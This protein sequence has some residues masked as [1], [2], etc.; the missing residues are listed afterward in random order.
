MPGCSRKVQ[1]YTGDPV[2]KRNT[3]VWSAGRDFWQ[4][5]RQEHAPCSHTPCPLS[6]CTTTY[7]ALAPLQSHYL[8]RH[9]T[10][11][12]PT[13]EV[14]WAVW[15][16]RIWGFGE[17]DRHVPLAQIINPHLVEQ[18]LGAEFVSELH[19]V[20]LRARPEVTNPIDGSAQ[21]R[22]GGELLFRHFAGL[23]RCVTDWGWPIWEP[24]AH[25]WLMNR[26]DA[27]YACSLAATSSRR[28]EPVL[29]HARRNVTNGW[30]PGYAC[31]TVWP[32]YNIDHFRGVIMMAQ[33]APGAYARLHALTSGRPP[34]AAWARPNV[35][36]VAVNYRQGAGATAPRP[37]KAVPRI[38][39][40]LKVQAQREEAQAAMVYLPPQTQAVTEP[41]RVTSL[42]KAGSCSTLSTDQIMRDSRWD[43]IEDPF[44][45][46]VLADPSQPPKV[47]FS[48]T[49]PPGSKQL[50]KEIATRREHYDHAVREFKK[51]PTDIHCRGS[52]GA[53][54]RLWQ[55]ALQVQQHRGYVN[56]HKHRGSRKSVTSTHPQVTGSSAPV[57]PQ[58]L[59]VSTRDPPMPG[60]PAN[61][62]VVQAL[63]TPPRQVHFKDRD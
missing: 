18:D 61:K 17:I 37:S 12:S 45:W 5:W 22:L 13:E 43:L 46:D 10:T 30:I 23:D 58:D 28:D 2:G 16:I 44:V 49:L 4:H 48:D 8:G 26:E 36:N 55:H 7:G 25:V 60:T 34:R 29:D 31:T 39:S 54:H 20:F 27:I 47:T 51:N 33:W 35:H 15:Q 50:T 59:R 32:Q 53:Y 62:R 6:D 19:P 1:V 9:D 40:I 21:R 63:E 24:P 52:C 56:T 42:P 3:D 38:P 14:R 57:S 41:A 11:I